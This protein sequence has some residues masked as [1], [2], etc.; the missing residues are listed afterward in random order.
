MPNYP[1]P[2][3][4]APQ[5]ITPLQPYDYTAAFTSL[6]KQMADVEYKRQM[7]AAQWERNAIMRERNALA[8]ERAASGGKLT[9]KERA[10]AKK[11]EEIQAMQSVLA[12]DKEI[13]NILTGMEGHSNQK[14][15]TS[16]LPRLRKRIGDLSQQYAHIGS[17][18]EF[19]QSFL[20]QQVQNVAEETSLIK[21]DPWLSTALDVAGTSLANTWDAITAIA[22]TPQER[23]AI[24][25]ANIERR[26][27]DIE[28][29]PYLREQELRT[30][31]GEGAFSRM[32][33]TGGLSNVALFG[34]ENLA[35]PVGIAGAALSAI[36]TGGLSLPVTGS[37]LGLSGA[38]TAG[39]TASGYL[40]RAAT[41]PRLTEEQRQAAFESTG[42]LAGAAATGFVSGAVPW[43]FGRVGS[44]VARAAAPRVSNPVISGMLQKAATPAPRGLR[45]AMRD[46]ALGG[47]EGAVV[48]GGS[49]IG[50]NIA[51]GSGSGADIPALE[52]VG[53]SMLM[54]GLLGGPM[55]AALGWKHRS[56]RQRP[57]RVATQ[58]GG[59][60]PE[61]TVTP[62]ELAIDPVAKERATLSSVRNITD[63]AIEDFVNSPEMTPDSFGALVNDRVNNSSRFKLPSEIID[64]LKLY[65]KTGA[66]AADETFA[67]ELASILDT[68]PN[69]IDASVEIAGQISDAVNNWRTSQ[70]NQGL[71]NVEASARLEK[72]LGQGLY[73]LSKVTKDTLRDNPADVILPKSIKKGVAFIDKGVFGI[74]DNKM[75]SFKHQ[76]LSEVL[77]AIKKNPDDIGQNL[78][79]IND[80]YNTQR[81]IKQKA[82]LKK[83]QGNYKKYSAETRGKAKNSV[84]AAFLKTDTNRDVTLATSR[85]DL[86]DMISNFKLPPDINPEDADIAVN[87]FR[88]SVKTAIDNIKNLS[89]SISNKDTNL[90]TFSNKLNDAKNKI[91]DA[92]LSQDQ[93]VNTA[94][95]DTIAAIQNL[96]DTNP[97]NTAD[98][99]SNITNAENKIKKLETVIK[100]NDRKQSSLSNINKGIKGHSDTIQK[101]PK[102]TNL[103]AALKDA[104][105]AAAELQG[106]NPSD[107]DLINARITNAENKVD[108]LKSAIENK[109]AELAQNKKYTGVKKSAAKE[110]DKHKDTLIPKQGEDLDTYIN[111]ILDRERT[112][113][114]GI[115][116]NDSFKLLTADDSE[117]LVKDK[118]KQWYDSFQKE[119]A[120]QIKAAQEQQNA[121]EPQVKIYTLGKKPIQKNQNIYLQALE[122]NGEKLSTNKETLDKVIERDIKIENG[123]KLK[124]NNIDSSIQLNPNLRNIIEEGV[125]AGKK[126]TEIQG[127]IIGKIEVEKNAQKRICPN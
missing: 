48:S 80:K 86:E 7:A 97:A 19:F 58:E 92:K 78:A 123:E 79:I 21:K 119:Q 49:T 27:Q 47:I 66:N 64:K 117:S 45:G 101:L 63:K 26:R 15:L 68:K 53:E 28:Q 102:D 13:Q 95:Q 41:D 24:A 29:H 114:E 35:I 3:L 106:T 60:S 62:E 103:D 1:F 122:I 12:G 54:G 55:S 43:Q 127:E 108:A 76:Y 88:S 81:D 40:E 77:D 33:G 31:E 120:E 118:A 11:A 61:T 8:R 57:Q 112:D 75:S 5:P 125:K 113:P 67:N 10:A 65:R 46:L 90:S 105:D 84:D 83:A 71:N 69:D 110:L 74:A 6:A 50:E 121:Q 37:I 99:N 34:A 32:T 9:G 126:D 94:L 25:K 70:D 56:P 107:I 104:A 109:K 38:L 36:P 14:K 98:L 20:N 100:Q 124:S 111:R 59:V 39:Q 22:K 115:L 82:D 91:T 116:N 17:S 93:E 44:A 52:N 23:E 85:K 16:D 89:K 51:I 73:P 72:L 42:G 87:N 96:K 30:Q 2:S 4:P 18:G